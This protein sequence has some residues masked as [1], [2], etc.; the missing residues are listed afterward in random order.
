MTESIEEFLW[1][2][3]DPTSKPDIL[4]FNQMVFGVNSSPFGAQFV[5][6]E[7]AK[8]HIETFPMGSTSVLESTYMDDTMDSVIDDKT[9]IKFI[10][11]CQNFDNQLE[12]MQG[13]GCL[14]Q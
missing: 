4:Q 7:H 9:G 14:T 3:L 5:S 6:R 13:S 8:E 2:N 1:R 11:N 10:M 12:C